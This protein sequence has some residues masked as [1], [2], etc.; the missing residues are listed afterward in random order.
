M[1]GRRIP[2]VSYAR[3][4]VRVCSPRPPNNKL[5]QLEKVEP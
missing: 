2:H 5:L 3:E 1:A 4:P